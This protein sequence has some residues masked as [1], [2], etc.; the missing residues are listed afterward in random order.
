[1]SEKKRI[2]C[3][4]TAGYT[5]L[6]A[7]KVFMRKINANSEY[8]QLCPT[9][10]RR[11]AE[12]IR[13]RN[14]NRHTS[15]IAQNGYTGD[16]LIEFIVEFIGKEKFNR[17]KY[18]AILIEDDKDNR[19]LNIQDDGTGKADCDGWKE[20][21]DRVIQ[22]VNELHPGIPVIFFL[23]APE[24]EIWFLADWE[25]GFGSVFKNELTS[26]Q[27][28]FFS[29]KFRKYVNENIL[30]SIYK[31]HIEEYGYFEGKYRKLSEEIQIAL[32]DGNFWEMNHDEGEYPSISYSKREQGADMMEKINPD[33]VKDKCSL[34]FKEGFYLLHNI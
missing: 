15:D 20:Y 23:A 6:N 7:L 4:F 14:T 24:A 17:E 3:F 10:A 18:D 22:R 34:F 33:V 5:E 13:N 2:A 19:F 1:M 25:N 16:K 32:R 31:K 29:T 27:N 11:S 21:K 12:D 8:I 9:R 28:S 26:S 30:T